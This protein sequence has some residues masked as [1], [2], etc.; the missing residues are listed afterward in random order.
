MDYKVLTPEHRAQALKQRIGSLESD[1]WG[2][3]MNID[4]LAAQPDSEDK[5]KAIEAAQAMQAQIEVVHEV[6]VAELA[7]LD[8]NARPEGETEE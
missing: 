1:H 6:A 3:Q 2:H 4:G 8:P 7:V 5:T